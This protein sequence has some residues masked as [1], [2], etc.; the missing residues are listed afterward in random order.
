MTS[1]INEADF[2]TGHGNGG[3]N[4]LSY[5]SGKFLFSDGRGVAARAYGVA[6]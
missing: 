6:L 5:A 1:Y 3:L 4:L 2:G